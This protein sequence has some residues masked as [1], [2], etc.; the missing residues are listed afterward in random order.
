MNLTSL[1]SPMPAYDLR[2]LDVDPKGLARAAALLGTVLNP[3]LDCRYLIWLYAENPG[4]AAV[5]FNAFDGEILAAHYAAIPIAG[6]L[7]GRLEKGLLSL[8]TAT[9]AAHQ[10]RGL[11]PR[12]AERTFASAAEAGFGFVIGVANARSTRGFTEK[13]GFQLVAPLD[14]QIGIGGVEPTSGQG[15]YSY[16]PHRTDEAIAW[17]LRRP[18]ARYLAG[19]RHGEVQDVLARVSRWGLSTCLD[20][21]PAHLAEALTPAR[22]VSPFRLTIG[23]DR[24]ARRRGVLVR[25]PDRLKPSPLNLIFRDLSGNQRTLDAAHVRWT[26]FDFDAY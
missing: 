2:A 7:D 8:N 26:L 17:R 21:I 4:G 9:H 19:K 1:S 13:L 14:V 23:L 16:A 11:F 24:S 18:G 6:F 25:V 15:S 5:G 10:G 3:A 22:V 12:L 20:R